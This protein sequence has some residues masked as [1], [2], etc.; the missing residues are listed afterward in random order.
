MIGYAGDGAN[1]MMGSNNSLKTR[2]TNDIPGLF[3][4]KCICHSFHLCASYACLKL[5]TYVEDFTRYVYNYISNS[6]KRVCELKD[7]QEK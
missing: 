5:P 1:N 7:F 6:P 2:L 4:L 3:V